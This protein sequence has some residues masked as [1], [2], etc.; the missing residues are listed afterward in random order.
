MERFLSE[1]GTKF[2][3]DHGAFTAALVLD[4]KHTRFTFANRGGESNCMR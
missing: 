1:G 3:V 2:V 4:N